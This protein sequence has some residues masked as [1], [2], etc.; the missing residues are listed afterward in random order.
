MVS[1][2]YADRSNGYVA[3]AAWSVRKRLLGCSMT[4]PAPAPLTACRLSLRN[5]LLRSAPRSVLDKNNHV[6]E[7]S[8]NLIE[9]VHLEDFEA[10]LLQGDGNEMAGKFRAAHSSSALAVNTF[11]PFKA[12]LG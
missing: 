1:V 9:G 11:A 12:H 2:I 5:G 3:E 8:Q 6:D 7:A 4:S 10:D